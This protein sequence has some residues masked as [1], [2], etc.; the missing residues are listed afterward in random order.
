LPAS[1]IEI[2]EQRVD[3]GIRLERRRRLARRARRTRYDAPF[4]RPQTP[5]ERRQCG[6]LA[7]VDRVVGRRKPAGLH[8]AGGG[9]AQQG[10]VGAGQVN[11]L[12]CFTLSAFILEWQACSAR[13]PV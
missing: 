5:G 12:D 2:I 9:M 8:C 3:R 7:G 11:V 6:G 13:K 4:C 1:V 10:Y